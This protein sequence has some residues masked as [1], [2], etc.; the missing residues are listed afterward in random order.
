MNQNI[1]LG[2]VTHTC[3]PSTGEIEEKTG[4][5]QPG[6]LNEYPCLRKKKEIRKKTNKR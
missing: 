3:N 1:R 2:L 4:R 6:L 5:A